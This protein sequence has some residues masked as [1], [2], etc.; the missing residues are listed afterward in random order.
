MSQVEERPIVSVS[1]D[2][3][4]SKVRRQQDAFEFGFIVGCGVMGTAA[5]LIGAIIVSWPK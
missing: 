3:A 5:M 4:I 2:E 1:V